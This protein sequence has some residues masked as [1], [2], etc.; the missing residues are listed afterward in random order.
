MFSLPTDQD[1]LSLRRER[2]QLMKLIEGISQNHSLAIDLRILQYGATRETLR[3]VL[4]EK[5]GWD[6]I[7]FSGHGSR[8]LL[9]LEKD[10][11]TL[12]PIN[13][14]DIQRLLRRTKH[15][16]KLVTLSA[17]LSAAATLRETR[18]WLGL[19][20]QEGM[21]ETS[22]ADE[23]E[24]L[25][26]VASSLVKD[27]DCAVL[28]MR[29]SVGDEFAI[30]LAQELYEGMLGREQTLTSALQV[31][32]T[33]ILDEGYNAGT[34][35]LS[36][37]IP[38]LFGERAASLAIEA[39]KKDFVAPETPMEG[40]PNEPERFVGRMDALGRA[41][42]AM[43]HKSKRSGVLF[44]GMA[45]AGK[46]ACAIELAY[47][48]CRSRRFARFV[49]YKAPK[50]GDDIATSLRDLAMAMES[51]L[52]GFKMI[53]KVDREQEFEKWLPHL[54]E[55][56]EKSSILVVLDNLE[57]LLTSEGK[58]RDEKWGK[59]IGAMLTKEGM[60]RV[61]LTSRR[62]PIEIDSKRF[63]VV[64]IHALS[65]NEALLL[66]REMPNLGSMLLGKSSAGLVEGRGLVNR[67]LKL[68]QGHPKLI[69]L[70]E[71]QAIN[72]ETLTSYLDKAADAW[73]GKDSQLKAFFEKGE[74]S[75]DAKEFLKMLH[76]WTS[77][78]SATLSDP[79]RTLF[80]FLCALEDADRLDWIVKLVWPE[81]WKDL[82]LGGDAPA[83]EQALASVKSVGLVEQKSQ[84]EQVRYVIHPGVAQAGLEE[85]DEK[86]RAVV[87]SEMATF[88][89][90]VF[91]AAGSGG[92]EES[93]QQVI[94]A[95]L[96]SAPYLMRQ[97]R[98]S[99]STALLEQAIYRDNSPETVASV[100]PQ[101]RHIAQATAE[102]DG[103]GVLATALLAAGRWQEAEDILRS[104]IPRC[105][106]Q[107][108][109]KLAS[110][111]AG[112][113]FN[114]L[115]QTGRFEEA[116]RLAEEKK[117]YT[118]K[119]GL[120]PWTQLLDE[121]QRLQVLN[122]MGRYEE[123]LRA[124][125]DLGE[126]MKNL[127]EKSDQ[128]ET[129]T[130]WNVRE[131]MLDTGQTAA[132]RLNKHEIALE[133][134][135]AAIN[136]KRSRGATELELAQSSFNDYKPLL[137]L[138]HYDEAESLLSACREVFE[139]ER[140]VQGLGVV[141]SALADLVDKLGQKDQAIS[142][143]ET[144]L[145]YKYIFGEPESISISHHNLAIYLRET[146]SKSALD[147]RLAGA[148]IRFQISSGMLASSLAGLA[149]NLDQFGPEALP[150]SFDQLCHRVE[151]VDGVRFRE[152]W[153]RL[154][155]RAEDGDQL[156][157]DLIEAAWPRNEMPDNSS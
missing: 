55:T 9:A 90:A 67:T 126:Q 117:T 26:S 71:K 42:K 69:E 109:F 44:Y 36:V 12:D 78:T 66:A 140:S 32:M 123:V 41:N 24:V 72:P 156:L 118:R 16:V 82:G 134:N 155:K 3:D 125:E 150:E 53:S 130:S 14:R 6:L 13:S 146:G 102:I 74:S 23:K 148:I 99:E 51:Q 151:E 76:D 143:E 39:P 77:A 147:H 75:L 47:H 95:G 61:I 139:K 27:L 111:I 29:Y 98:W 84:G 22:K 133:L 138:K 108:D 2:Y 15:R 31:A 131:A 57:S 48:Y 144:A 92:A 110:A 120:G 5:D 112:Y 8:A 1:A 129:A 49:W 54:T 64:P 114:I 62:K 93:G 87:D 119:A 28:A 7:H 85:A 103:S 135:A 43:A 107:A 79:A 21:S 128:V 136:V 68:V 30:Q 18:K 10:N 11:G 94:M 19:P 121:G 88:W 106:V 25:P 127:P 89:R 149:M 59:L 63:C 132:M 20:E 145:R 80:Q 37:A 141:F 50:E 122:N 116:L 58:W 81:I 96:R 70:A 45:G 101:L 34:P 86:L 46:S 124:V 100:L 73:I 115:R 52:P 142:F 104:L 137:S 56:L 154:P 40:F 60:S 35:P 17:C 105:I 157:K 113:L 97:K 38:A 33:K 4:A 65:L 91:D 152:L 153:A 83:L